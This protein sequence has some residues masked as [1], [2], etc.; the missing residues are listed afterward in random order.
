MYSFNLRPRCEC[1]TK[2]TNQELRKIQAKWSEELLK[3]EIEFS[4][5]KYSTFPVLALP[6]LTI[7]SRNP[8]QLFIAKRPL[9]NR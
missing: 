7:E 9:L 4:S 5:R 2:L 8:E 1:L 3:L 6:R